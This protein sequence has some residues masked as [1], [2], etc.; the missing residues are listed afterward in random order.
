[1]SKL[2]KQESP[3]Q[4]IEL[5]KVKKKKV[6]KKYLQDDLIIQDLQD[7]FLLYSLEKTSHLYLFS[8]QNYKV[9]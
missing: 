3:M 7:S 5:P 6:K 9:V 1:M 2:R 8:Q 4:G